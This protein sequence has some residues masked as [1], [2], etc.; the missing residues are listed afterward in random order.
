VTAVGA[1][2]SGGAGAAQAA[3]AAAPPVGVDQPA[4]EYGTAPDQVLMGALTHSAGASLGPV[5]SMRLDPLAGTAV[6]PLDNVVGTQVADFKPV[7]TGAA[8][9]ALAGGAAL[10]DLPVVGRAAGVLPG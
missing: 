1:A 8:T 3:P 9:E 5:K 2:L 10:E 4:D 6:D 7:S